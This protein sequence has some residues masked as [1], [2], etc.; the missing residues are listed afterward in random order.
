MNE[1][2]INTSPAP[3]A[4]TSE[5]IAVLALYKEFQRDNPRY[6]AAEASWVEFAIKT[7]ETMPPRHNGKAIPASKLVTIVQG[8]GVSPEQM[9]AQQ[10]AAVDAGANGYVVAFDEIDQSWSPKIVSSTRWRA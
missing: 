3:V 5:R 7:F 8:W 6:G 9:K 1:A 4:N 10:R 2:M